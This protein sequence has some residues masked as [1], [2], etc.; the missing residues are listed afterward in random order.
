[1]LSDA[2]RSTLGEIGQR[3]GRK[4]LAEVATVAQPDTILA[5]YRKL[6]ARKFSGSQAHQG[7]GRPR[8][9]RELEQLIFAWRARTGTGATTGSR[10][11]G[12]GKHP[13]K[14]LSRRPLK[15]LKPR[16]GACVRGAAMRW[17]TRMPPFDCR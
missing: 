14:L 3:L 5:W 6:V 4:V 16:Y 17:A 8:L 7:P 2:E 10:R 15:N 13:S 9:K 12:Q 11:Q 1:M